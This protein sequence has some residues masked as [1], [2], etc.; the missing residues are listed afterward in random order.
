MTDLLPCPLC[1]ATAEH[2]QM[3]FEDESPDA[4]GYFIRCTADDCLV[5]MGLRFA[6][7]DDPRPELIAAWNRRA[8]SSLVAGNQQAALLEGAQEIDA[9]AVSCSGRG[10]RGQEEHQRGYLDGLRRAATILRDRARSMP[11][12]GTEHGAD[13]A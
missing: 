6:C 1:G 13:N 3:P 11:K 4:G 12:P 7:G 5:G 9:T 8:C 10:P 2:G